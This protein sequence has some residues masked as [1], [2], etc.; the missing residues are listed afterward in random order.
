[1]QKNKPDVIFINAVVLLYSKDKE[2]VPNEIIA[3][4]RKLPKNITILV[5][6]EKK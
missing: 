5:F 2:N 6:S 1:M 4:E 3:K